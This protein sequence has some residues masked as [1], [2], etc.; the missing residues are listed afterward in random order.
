MRNKLKELFAKFIIVLC[1]GLMFI[2][3]VGIIIFMFVIM[4]FILFDLL[5]GG[6]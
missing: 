2:L 4:P 5:G 3:A 6:M 1:Y